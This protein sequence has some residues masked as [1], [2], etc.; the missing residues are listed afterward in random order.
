MKRILSIFICCLFI[1]VVH[2]QQGVEF[3]IYPGTIPNSIP[4]SNREKTTIVDQYQRVTDVSIP[5]L[6]VFR[7]E[8]PNGKAIIVCPGG[9]YHHLAFE[10]EGTLVAQALCKW[11]ITAFVLKYRLP[12]DSTCID[13][14]LAPLQ[15]AQQAIRSLRE[16]NE[17]WGILKN[18]IGIMGFSAGG[19]LASTAATHFDFRA[20]R[21]NLDTVS[22]RP[23]FAMLIYPVISFDTLSKNTGT[24]HHLLGTSADA[25]RLK[26]FSSECQVTAL[27]S[28]V[29]IVH[30]E[31]D[32][33]ASVMNSILFYEACLK[34]KVAATLHLYATGGHGFGLKNKAVTDS[35]TESL[36][37]WLIDLK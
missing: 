5:T 26:F 24:L 36:R 8:H 11:D 27:T 1:I 23:D 14:S 19:H 2:A 3:P 10:K 25:A 34:N 13:K 17:R 30:A 32:P 37:N 12:N 7:P 22:V 16:N 28:P 31:D 20:D 4:V 18:R 33:T 35:W 29:F 15:D 6:T 9:G 21:N